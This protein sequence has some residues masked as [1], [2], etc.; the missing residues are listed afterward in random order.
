[1]CKVER[2]S[3]PSK[4]L[5]LIDAPTDQLLPAGLLVQPG[6]LSDANIDNNCFTV[7]IQNE[8][9]KT[10][11]IPV[12]TIIA[13]MYAVD[14][15]TLVQPSHL[16]A[17]TLDPSL[18]N[19]GDSPIPE[20]WKSRL[21][22]KLAERQNVFSLHEWDVGRAKGVEHHIRVHDP[23]P[24]RERSRRL[25]PADIDDVRL[26]IQQLLATGIIVP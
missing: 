24:F 2:Q 12:G 9:K 20:E 17:E 22:Q 23:R 25:A 7:L 8:S 4:D 15:V 16:P 26:H 3:P 5:V 13:E 18:F 1:M 11:Y 6:V 19:V 14:T 21:Q 10:T